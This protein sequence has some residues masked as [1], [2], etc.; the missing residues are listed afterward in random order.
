MA[1]IS[2][3]LNYYDGQV[4]D[5]R[6]GLAGLSTA[7]PW[8]EDFNSL[9]Q[10]IWSAARERAVAGGN[11]SLVLDTIRKLED[12]SKNLT[13]LLE[14][15][16]EEFEHLKTEMGLLSN[17]SQF[18]ASLVQSWLDTMEKSGQDLR[19]RQSD[20]ERNMYGLNVSLQHR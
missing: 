15:K 12:S 3:S 20:L 16:K 4:A 19:L 9:E 1:K 7:Q 14:K 5:L 6:T 13:G 10:D 8:K 2:A 17:S 18:V 11:I